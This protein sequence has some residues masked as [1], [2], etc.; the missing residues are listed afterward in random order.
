MM[1]VSE[2]G[3][4]RQ[5]KSLEL[6]ADLVV[7]GGG[8]SG[9]CA[10]ITAA[11]AGIKVIL[12]QDRPVIGGN[13][14]S[15]VR[16]WILGATS[17]M[18]NNNRWARE[19][20]VIDEILVENLWRNPEGNPVILD[21][22]LLE[23][24]KQEPG[25][26][27]LLNTAVDDV[28]M[29]TLGRIVAVQAFC[30]Q[31]QL[32]YR[33][34]ANLFCDASGDGVLGFLAGAAFR[35]GAESTAEFG[36]LL[37][38]TQEY[39]ELLGNSLYFYSRD[40]GKPVSFVRPS[41]ALED[42]ARLPRYR[43]IK[44]SDSGCRL[45]WLEY[46]G[47]LDT[48]HDTEL[49]KWELWRVALGIW[50]Y[51]KN[52]GEFPGSETLT[53]EWIGA[54][55]GKRESRRFEGLSMMRQQDIVEQKQQEDAVSFGGWAID[56]HPADGVY[57]PLPSCTQWHAK[58]VYQIPYRSMVSRN[59]PNLFLTGR[60]ISAS[61]VAFGSTRVMA[62]SAHNGQAVGMASAICTERG[63]LPAE[64]LARDNIKELQRRLLRGGQHIPGLVL[65]DPTDLVQSAEV[66]ASS[67]LLLDRL[68][69]DGTVESLSVA[70]AL[71]LPL[72]VGPLPA[73]TFTLDV[74]E[75]TE[76]RAEWRTA[77]RIGNYTPDKLLGCQC[78]TL[79]RGERQQVRLACNQFLGTANYV[80]V[81][82]LPN[83]SVSVHLSDER[84]TGVLTVSQTMNSAVATSTR[85]TPPEGTGI[86]TFDF[87]L[88]DRRPKGRNMAVSVAPPLALYRAE[89]VR[90][91]LSRPYQRTNAWAAA[92]GDPTPRLTLCWK[93]P[94][95][96]RRIMIGFDTDFDHPMESVL[97][98]H[99]ERRVPFCIERYRI[100]DGSG[101][102]LYENSE[103]HQT[104]NTITFDPQIEV[105]TLQIEMAHPE[106]APAAVFRISAYAT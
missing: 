95:Q 5:F 99:P 84:L 40:T 49:I 31:S 105:D 89:F 38:P 75:E 68:E 47:R 17:H 64:L 8:L 18:G 26:T 90:N 2:G 67:T 53:L 24:V 72:E 10:A 104:L 1:L 86:D 30:S 98:T 7:V 25:I 70:R 77:S 82:L 15:E 54:I 56:L 27:L 3:S 91:G 66:T 43:Q 96:I 37:A 36:E 28:E 29:N 93:E 22:L 19:G 85:Q 48:I 101:R 79:R 80:F 45:W 59:V 39:G 69:P 74:S 94:Q 23:K 103:N 21:L 92:Q 34:A 61:H 87:W 88:P 32:A 51:I 16:L 76:L 63:I 35:M 58:G 97:L 46:G 60:I 55:A 52:S 50:N 100:L 57:S 102:L 44:L 71:L 20:G 33:L 4:R 42:I 83:P 73:F 106:Q 65:E 78:I 62:T 81:C 14:S 9:T 12:V 13:A 6:L 11:R 41:Y